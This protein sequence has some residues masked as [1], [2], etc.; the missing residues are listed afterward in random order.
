MTSST[1]TIGTGSSDGCQA[2]IPS[3]TSTRTHR[4]VA[5]T[6]GGT[7]SS[8]ARRRTSITGSFVAN[9]ANHCRRAR[10]RRHAP[11]STRPLA[12]S[13]SPGPGY[14]VR[15]RTRSGAPASGSAPRYEPALSTPRQRP[16]RNIPT[17]SALSTSKAAA[18]SGRRRSAADSLAR[19]APRG[20]G[21]GGTG[22]GGAVFPLYWV[23][24][25]T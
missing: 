25:Q 4:S 19:A 3:W 20:G 13:S 1:S 22:A 2:A 5:E 9:S 11:R 7:S 14:G 10:P 12:S 16:A 15:P 6:A 17:R 23:G 24:N 21:L 18:P 8:C